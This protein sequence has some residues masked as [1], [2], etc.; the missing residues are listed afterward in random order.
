LVFQRACSAAI[1]DT[2]SLAVV[3]ALA[4]HFRTAHSSLW[5]RARQW[6]VARANPEG[7][8]RTQ[9]ALVDGCISQHELGWLA[10]YEYLHDVLGFQQETEVLRGL[11]LMGSCAGW[12]R[13]H[14][15]VCWL[16]ERHN[17]LNFDARGRLH[18]ANGPAL[19]FPDGWSYFAWKG[20]EVPREYIERPELITMDAI[21]DEPDIV[22]RHSMIE[23]I[24]PK[25]FI[26]MYGARLISSDSTGKLWRKT[27]Y[28]GDAWAAVEVVNGTAAPDG[29]RQSYFL[30][31]P[32]QMRTARAA[33]AWTYGIS[34]RQYGALVLRT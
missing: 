16:A 17:V 11:W 23:I 29:S 7:P 18:S 3:E 15:H 1:D 6:I 28:D 19:A 31:V 2:K 8:S 24:T 13:P 22:V 27:W 33:V 14:A 26:A 4:R 20:V 32:P 10:P 21:D 30:Q 12:I 25:R 5:T 34:E 9:P